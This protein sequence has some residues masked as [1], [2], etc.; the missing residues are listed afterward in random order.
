MGPTFPTIPYF[1]CAPLFTTFLENALLS[2]LFTLKYHSR[3]K[4]TEFCPL[5]I[6]LLEFYKLSIIMFQ[7]VDR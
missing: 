6:R 5:S 7:G 1:S 4:N 2:L 3:D